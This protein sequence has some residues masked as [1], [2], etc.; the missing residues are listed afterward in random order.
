[1]ISVKNATANASNK[2]NGN[3]GMGPSGPILIFTF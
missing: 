2:I 3:L 1:M